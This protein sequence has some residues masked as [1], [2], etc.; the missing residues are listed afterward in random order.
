VYSVI[1]RDADSLLDS[2]VTTAAAVAVATTPSHFPRAFSLKE[3]KEIS[4][5]APWHRLPR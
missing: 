2:R 3:K 5:A 4:L 1:A